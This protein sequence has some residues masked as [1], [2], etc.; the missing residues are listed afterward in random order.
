MDNLRLPRISYEELR[1]RLL[2]IR[3]KEHQVFLMLTYACMARIGEIVCGKYHHNPPVS[4]NNIE[5]AVSSTGKRFLKVTILTE[6][7]QTYRTV[8]INRDAEAWLSEPILQ[9]SEWKQGPLFPYSTRW[10]QKVFARYFGEYGQHIHWMRG[11][12]Y[13]HYRQGK[14]TGRPVSGEWIYRIGGW[15]SVATPA[16]YYDATITEDYEEWL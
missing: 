2:A 1:D 11:W 7:L 4:S 6:K 10:G 5:T 15:G 16:K 12:R 9:Y 3:I 13:T 8:P 14:V